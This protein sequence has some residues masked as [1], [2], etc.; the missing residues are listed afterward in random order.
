MHSECIEKKLK[1]GTLINVRESVSTDF[2]KFLEFFR[3]L[4]EEDRQ[5]L[6]IDV[7]D[8]KYVRLRMN[9]G[10]FQW[11]WRIVA[12]KDG[13]IYGDATLC[14]HRNGWMRHA[15]E[16]RCIIHPDFRRKGLG[17]LLLRELFLKCLSDKM[18]MI[19]CCVVPEQKTAITVLERLGFKRTMVRTNHI[20]D[21]QGR[22]RDLYIYSK[23]VP[24]MWDMLKSYMDR[25]DFDISVR[26]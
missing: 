5:Y 2:E 8:P 10:P 22:R 4:P 25:Y 16:I 18:E 24:E 3:S 26:H 17:A 20:K 14:G 13:K 23:N 7:T 19:Y 21:I 12:E 9:P 15:A 6:R 11:C 1:D